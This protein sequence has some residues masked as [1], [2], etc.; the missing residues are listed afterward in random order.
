VKEHPSPFVKGLKL[1][2]DVLTMMA[3]QHN[4]VK[5]KVGLHLQPL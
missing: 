1:A 2:Q 3:K 4:H 5:A